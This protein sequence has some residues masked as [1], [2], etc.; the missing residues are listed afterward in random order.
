MAAVA[1]PV[2]M[3]SSLPLAVAQRHPEQADASGGDEAD[4][5]GGLIGAHGFAGSAEAAWAYSMT[6][7]PMPPRRPMLTSAT[8]VRSPRSPR[9]AQ[10]GQQIG[11]AAGKRRRRRIAQWLAP[12]MHEVDVGGVRADRPR[13]APTATG[14]KAR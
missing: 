8:T 4:G 6:I 11:T 13:N 3:R 12:Y 2:V 9:R 10:R 5:D 1:G 7:R 14:K